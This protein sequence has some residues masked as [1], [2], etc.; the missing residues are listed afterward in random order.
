MT[1]L[2]ADKVEPLDEV[3]FT[4]EGEVEVDAA[5][6]DGAEAVLDVLDAA[7]GDRRA[8]GPDANMLK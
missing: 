7:D 2:L 6:C 8:D 4:M 5:H 3:E 1:L